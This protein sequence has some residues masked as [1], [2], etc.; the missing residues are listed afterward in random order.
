MFNR[1]CIVGI[2]LIGGSFG[3]ELRKRG[4][5]QEVVGVGR[6]QSTIDD[7]VQ[8]GSCDSGTTDL[9]A[10]A[11][12]ADFV[13]LAP[14]VGQMQS[15]CQQ[16]APFLAENAIVTDAGSTKAQIVAECE[17]IFGDKVSFLG[18]HPMAGSEQKGAQAAREGLFLNAT[19][20]LTP[21][22]KT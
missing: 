13:F 14:P 20:V 15:I 11:T 1:V 17:P 22:A 5:A 7:A 12:G 8:L 9:V 10:G 2:G 19:W 18:G 4:L 3:L 6:R 16:I 21:T